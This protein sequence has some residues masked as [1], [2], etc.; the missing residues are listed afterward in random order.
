MKPYRPSAP[1]QFVIITTVP[2]WFLQNSHFIYRSRTEAGEWKV[3]ALQRVNERQRKTMNLEKHP[4]HVR[5]TKNADEYYMKLCVCACA[6]AY[7]IYACCI[8]VCFSHYRLVSDENVP[9]NRQHIQQKWHL[10]LCNPFES[11]QWERNWSF[12]FCFVRFQNLLAF[13]P[14]E[15]WIPLSHRTIS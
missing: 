4:K 7:H 6:C 14:W 9:W 10:S 11:K 13:F 8:L 15:L 3:G 2:Y 5:I 12:C 1:M